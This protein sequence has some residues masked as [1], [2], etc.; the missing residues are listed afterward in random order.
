MLDY[1]RSVTPIEVIMTRLSAVLLLAASVAAESPRAP[2]DVY[3]IAML[4]GARVGHCHTAVRKDDGG[5]GRLRVTSSLELTLRRYSSQ[6]R[7]R[8]DWGTVEAADGKVL[9]VFMKQDPGASNQVELNGVVKDDK[10]VVKVEGRGERRVP[11]NAAVLGVRAQESLFAA[12]KPKAG[13][14]FTFHR[15]EPIYNAVLTVRVEVKPLEEVDV[16]GKKQKLLRVEMTPDEL[17]GS[18]VTIRPHKSVWWLDDSFAVVR[19]QTEMDGLGTITLIRT[20]KEKALAPSAPTVDLG[21]RSLVPLNRA[22]ARPYDARSVT[23]RVTVKGEDDPAGLF[24]SDAHQEARNAKGNSFELLVHPVSSASKQGK[25]KATAEYLGVSHYIDYKDT[26]IEEMTRQAVG[27]E[28]DAWKKAVR[29]ERYVKNHLVNDNS[30][31]L[32]PA[33]KIA[34]TRR[35]DCRHHAFLTAAMCRAAGLPSR[36]AIGLLYVNRGGPYLGFHTWVEVLIDGRWLG[37]DSTL[38][39]GG[40]SATHLKVTQHSWHEVQSLTPLLPVSRVTGRLKVEVVKVE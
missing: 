7:L 16:L 37:I 40:V 27:N 17:K 35:G 6:V 3:E 15:Y 12:K 25:E 29:I 39:K 1:L 32:A 34:K 13:D 36:T 11:W 4:D 21:K 10:L 14:K 30:A 19:K 5:D 33:S 22:I 20:T 31:E 2:E 26:R 18:N 8:M 28:K 23:Y 24:V 9:G 38:G